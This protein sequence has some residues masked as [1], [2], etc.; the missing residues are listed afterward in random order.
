MV[1]SFLIVTCFS[2]K[3]KL[4]GGDMTKKLTVKQ[5]KFCDEYIVT[6]NGTEAA[7][8]AGYKKNS[9]KEIASENLTKPNITAYIEKRL[10]ELDEKSI[11]KQKEVMQRLTKIGRREETETVVITVKSRRSYYEDG[12]KVTEE[13][14]EPKLI[15]IPS[16]LTDTN[17]A[18]ELIGRKY[19]LFTDRLDVEGEIGLVKIV[20]DI[21]D[22]S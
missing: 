11:M 12:K 13:F 18:L 22:D 3:Q 4:G 5:K 2:F 19:A 21:N 17:K 9:A 8:K 1:C 15:E 10:N 6:G 14:E 7:I 16:K 20:D